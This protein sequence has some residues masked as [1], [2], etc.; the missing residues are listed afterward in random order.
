MYLGYVDVGPVMTADEFVRIISLPENQDVTF[1]LIDGYVVRMSGNATPNHQEISLFIA[2]EIRQYLKGKNCK[3]Y[4]DLS[5]HLFHED[6]GKCKNV[7]QPDI[8]V[9]CDR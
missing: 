5:V 2:S 3:V 8:M 9:G 6:F 4:Q 7:F 1:E